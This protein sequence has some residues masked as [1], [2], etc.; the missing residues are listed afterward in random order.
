VSTRVTFDLASDDPEIQAAVEA[1]KDDQVAIWRLAA[2]CAQQQL[3][4]AV[5]ARAVRDHYDTIHMRARRTR[6]ARQGEAE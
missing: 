5:R 1:I 2:F 4:R 3:E 6:A